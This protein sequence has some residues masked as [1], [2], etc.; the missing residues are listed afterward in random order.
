MKVPSLRK[1]SALCRIAVTAILCL[2]K[3]FTEMQ[4]GKD[5]QR[6]R[7]KFTIT[8]TEI[9][10]WRRIHDLNQAEKPAAPIEKPAPVRKYII[11]TFELVTEEGGQ[12]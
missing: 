4:S 12:P 10:Y 6:K 11:Q 8:P 9:A 5:N 3:K 1:V 7:N 2:T